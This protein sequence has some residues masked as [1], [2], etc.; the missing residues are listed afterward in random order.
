MSREGEI[1]VRKGIFH[2]YLVSFASFFIVPLVVLSICLQFVM[3]RNLNKEILAY[4]KNILERLGDDLVGING[5]LMEAGNRISF[6]TPDVSKI[7]ETPNQIEL[8][9]LL[10]G[11]SG[12]NIY[13]TSAYLI[14]QD[15][16]LC[17]SS[18]GVY[19]KEGFLS[20]QLRMQKEQGL[21]FLKRLYA[22][23]KPSYDV[24]TKEYRQS[25]STF[26]QQQ[27]I[28]IYPVSNYSSHLNAWVVMELQ[29]SKLKLDLATSSGEYTRGITVLN[30]EGEEIIS[31][32]EKI[33]LEK[34]ISEVLG[35][36]RGVCRVLDGGL[37]GQ[38]L[39]A[40]SLGNLPMILVS[41]VDMP[42]LLASVLTSNSPLIV[43]VLAFLLLGCVT[44]IYV[45]Y[46]YY[47]PI[48]QLAQYMKKG[49]EPVTQ[50]NEL[51]Y[52]RG[53]YDSVN[54]VRESLAKEIESQW[55]LVEERLVTELL[56]DGMQD[57][58]EEDI[59]GK[60]FREQLGQQEHFVSLIAG[61]K[62]GGESF[63]AVYKE[64]KGRL[65]TELG[66]GYTVTSSYMYDYEI[67]A[68]IVGGVELGEESRGRVKECLGR[69]FNREDGVVA[70]GNTYRDP[71]GIHVSF[72]EALTA[73]KYQLL[74][75]YKEYQ[76]DGANQEDGEVYSQKISQYQTECFLTL[77][78]CM[79][80]AEREEVDKAV[81]EVVLNLEELPGQMAMM[82]C[83]DIVSR[84]IKEVKRRG[85]VIKEEELFRMTSFRTVEEFGEK[86]RQALARICE[87]IRQSKADTQN[88]LIRQI[89]DYI[90]GNYRDPSM[91][92][93]GMSEHFGYSSS[94]MSKIISQNLN[95]SFSE[96]VSGRRLHY[97]KECLVNSDKP[98]AQIAQEAGYGNLS[99]FT[100]RFKSSEN[101]TPGQYR[102]LYTKKEEEQ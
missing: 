32:G 72:L 70:L 92:L 69:L 15:G 79:D 80:L 99:N 64:N 39:L 10:R 67:I 47:K 54:S 45:A 28:F 13:A 74:N 31:K 97:T 22:V 73:V 38:K 42:N 18:R 17:F 8:I 62:H 11:E 63:A 75:P 12:E 29:E 25:D 61:R 58:K 4:N 51:D 5:R 16:D 95:Q 37:Q 9:N 30:Q 2:K 36:E 91:C 21:E 49:D 77:N 53:Q 76:L 43:G 7:T 84:M 26:Y 78:R 55:P 1:G 41:T 57:L 87:D 46:Y 48:H 6:R 86:L 96:L 90:E 27:M 89:Q 19:E 65:K 85:I 40:Y 71:A 23:K 93:V 3:Y 60:V 66:E 88:V 100:R 102:S 56:H 24:I 98:I 59:V 33:S 20:S 83:Y 44:A 34:N 14:Y 52:I 50:K 94:H 101:M 35:T 68:V 82:C 81:Q